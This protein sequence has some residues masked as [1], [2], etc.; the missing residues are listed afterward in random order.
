LIR[1]VDVSCSYGEGDVLSHVDLALPR[2]AAVACIGPNGCGKST[3]LKLL[4]GV[5]TARAGRYLLDGEE[6]GAKRL[7]D[8][9]FAKHF[10]QR[11]G[12][13]FQNSDAQLFCPLVEEEVAFGPRQMGLGEDD[14]ARRTDDCLKLLGI[15]GLRARVP[16]HLSEGEKR[17]VALASVL[18]MNPEVLLLDEPMNGLDPRMKGFLRGLVKDLHGAGKTILCSTHEFRYVEGLFDT[19][20]VLSAKHRVARVAPYAEVLGDE[21]F[22]RQENVL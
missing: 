13:L 15:E 2:G 5:V 14:V 18:A 16:Y 22:L 19:A 17:R 20:V 7:R 9:A 8:Q 6:V 4:A 12:L 3:L 21:A 11:V 10:H 1:L